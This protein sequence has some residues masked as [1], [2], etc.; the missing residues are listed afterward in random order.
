M[1]VVSAVTNRLLRYP[2]NRNTQVIG[3]M[4]IN[5]RGRFWR[6]GLSM[7]ARD[8]KRWFMR[9][10]LANICKHIDDQF[11]T[12]LVFFWVLGLFLRV[13]RYP[14]MVFVG[15]PREG[16]ASTVARA[17]PTGECPCWQD[18]LFQIFYIFVQ[19]TKMYLLKFLNIFVQITK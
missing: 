9:C 10:I 8:H 15:R 13:E 17:S 11:V 16:G 1:V 19:I 2:G 14:S 4:R 3:R 12:V 7:L 18:A 6:R 5:T